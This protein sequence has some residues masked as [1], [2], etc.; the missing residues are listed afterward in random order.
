[1]NKNFSSA[2]TT[3]FF[4]IV[5]PCSTCANQLSYP[6]QIN[7]YP[8]CPRRVAAVAQN[9]LEDAG[10]ATDQLNLLTLT[11]LED[12]SSGTSQTGL[13]NPV[14]SDSNNTVLVW[15]ATISDNGPT[16]DS[17]GNMLNPDLL[18]PGFNTK[19]ISCRSNPVTPSDNEATY[20][21]KGAWSEGDQ[22]N[23]HIAGAQQNLDSQGFT[24][25]LCDGFAEKVNF[26]YSAPRTP[27][28]RDYSVSGT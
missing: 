7:N 20:R 19:Y 14:Y 5:S 23:I 11:G 15:I 16:Y 1:M 8:A 9:E 6:D 10:F 24:P 22:L 17:N 13:V 4:G 12:S 3:N 21:S 27:L 26:T 28:E 25:I 2:K 18:N